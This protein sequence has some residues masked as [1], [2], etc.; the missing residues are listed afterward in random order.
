MQRELVHNRQLAAAVRPISFRSRDGGLWAFAV[1]PAPHRIAEAAEAAVAIALESRL[2]P[3]GDDELAAARAALESDLA[4]AGEGPA[5]RARRLGF[6][7][8]IVRDATE[9]RRYLEAIRTAD[10][11]ELRAA[12]RAARLEGKPTLA[13]ALPPGPPAGRDEAAD[14]LKPRLEAMLKTAPDRVQE[15]MT[16]KAPAVGPGDAVRFVTPAGIRVLRAAG[17]G[18]A[19]RLRRG[20]VGRPVRR[21]RGR[22]R[23]RRAPHRGAVRPWHPDPFGRGFRRRAAAAG[24]QREGLRRARDARVS[25]RLLAPPP[26]TRPRP[27]RG[28]AGLSSVSGAGDGGGGSRPRGPAAER[29]AGIRS[30]I[31]G[32]AEP[33]PRDVVAD[34]GRRAE[35][36]PTPT[37]IGLLDRYRR[38]YPLSRLVVAVVGDVD[39]AQVVAA[40][41]SAFPGG[42]AAGPPAVPPSA[43]TG[44]PAAPAPRQEPTTVFRA[45]SGAESAAVVGYPTFAPGDPEPRGDRGAGRD[46][47]RGWGPARGRARRQSTRL[48]GARA[49]RGARRGR[50]PRRRRSPARRR[51]STRRWRRC[52]RRSPAWPPRES[53]PTR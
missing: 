8:V 49:R 36:L 20:R 9:R 1:T 4:Q 3:A 51:G 10:P 11:G 27:G 26:R 41:T 23:R 45:G 28:R 29:V 18:G 44:V 16:R 48:S 40:V 34:A 35:A 2:V 24:R 22:G 50:V 47:R 37:R 21:R 6:A 43:P 30:G 19:A 32:G 42:P 14:V 25:G 5:A 52:A 12:T 46:P 53:R 7:S 39:P 13:V 38:R 33:V 17:R 15:R 31:A